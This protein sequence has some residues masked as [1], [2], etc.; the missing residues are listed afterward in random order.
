[1]VDVAEADVDLGLAD[2]A[3]EVVEVD[4]IC[5]VVAE[6]VDVVVADAISLTA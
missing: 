6:V 2:N 4:S 3:I 5:A 1:V